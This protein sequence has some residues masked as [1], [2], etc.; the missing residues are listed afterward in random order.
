M[1]K[2]TL[3]LQTVLVAAAS[4]A[5]TDAFADNI[6]WGNK[7]GQFVWSSIGNWLSADNT[8]VFMNRLPNEAD[9]VFLWAGGLSSS[10]LVVQN[11]EVA[12]TRNFS[13]SYVKN[14][15]TGNTRNIL[16]EIA[17]GGVMT[18]AGPVVLGNIASGVTSGRA[19]SGSA[20]VRSGGAWTALSNVTV[21]NGLTPSANNAHTSRVVVEQGGKM[22]QTA[23]EFIV[24]GYAGYDGVVTNAGELAA[25]DLL[26]GESG[27]GKFVNDGALAVANK[28]RVARGVGSSGTF[29]HRGGT[30]SH[31]AAS[32][33]PIRVG[34]LG[35]G[36]FEVAA[37]LAFTSEMMVVGNEN[38]SRGTLV[39]DDALSGIKILKLG[40]N[41]G[42]EGT[43]LLNGGSVTVN[44][45]TA[46]TASDSGHAIWVGMVNESGDQAQTATGRIQGHGKIG[47]TEVDTDARHARIKNYGRIVADGGDLDLGLFRLV[48][49]PT[50]DANKCGTNGWFAVNG[51]RLIYP[52]RLPVSSVNHVAVGDYGTFSGAD[53]N[54]DTSLV[55]SLQ[56]GLYQN[57]KQRISNNRTFAM[58]YASDRTDIPG[59]VPCDAAVGDKVLGVWR[60]GHFSDIGDVGAAPE[61]PW[62]AFDS[63]SVRIRFDDSKVDFSKDTVALYRYDGSTWRRVGKATSGFHVETNE[64]QPRYDSESDNWNIGWFAVVRKRIN[65]FVLVVR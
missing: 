8:T 65:P 58:L 55:N 12:L 41:A 18:N 37:P 10:P 30:I 25:C 46:A 3:I 29:V 26:V 21:G 50:V 36:R 22:E 14:S 6:A 16:F 23:G 9:D 28:F 62:S 53:G 13:I 1:R 44:A 64:L 49:L 7:T 24:A 35:T 52:R 34:Y 54:P 61:T 4:V 31:A 11:G 60:L 42:S 59:T 27:N 63:V 2:P 56:I 43:L 57:G 40:E 17:D 20:T 32:S 51:G 33:Q 19:V 39:V 48:G 15:S 47:R 5:P 38:G 45:T